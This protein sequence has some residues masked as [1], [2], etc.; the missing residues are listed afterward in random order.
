MHDEALR[1]GILVGVDGSS[2]SDAAVRW[3]GQE[4]RLTHTPITL[5]HVVAPTLAP[6]PKIPVEAIVTE[7]DREN[8]AKVIERARQVLSRDE[9]S[10]QH[11]DVVSVVHY[12]GVLPTLVDASKDA[13]MTVVGSRGMGAVRRLLMGSVS[14]GLVRHARGPVTV[15]HSND[16]RL[17]DSELPVVVGIDGSPASEAATGLAFEEAHNRGVGLVAV[18][19]WR[20]VGAMLALGIDVPAYERIGAEVLEDR[21]KDWQQRYPGVEV[22]RRLEGAT[23]ARWLVEESRHAQLVVVGSHGRGGF[24]GM[25]LGS[26]SSAV[27]QTVRIPVTVVRPR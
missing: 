24:A 21:L 17:P 27:A 3:A 25:T 2:E 11:V 26:V 20:D 8:A 7:W 22:R 19:A 10:D 14:S 18:H 13:R 4:A 23:P 9:T 15:V 12:W 16:G 5:M 1:Y 6:M